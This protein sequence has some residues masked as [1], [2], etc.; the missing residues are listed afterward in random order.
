MLT[1]SHPPD[2]PTRDGQAKLD[3]AGALATARRTIGEVKDK[4]G[5][6]DRER[7]QI[8]E[9]VRVMVVWM[10]VDAMWMGFGLVW[11]GLIYAR[12]SRWEWRALRALGGLTTATITNPRPL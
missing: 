2:T 8:C 11:F 1:S 3:Q 6:G 12:V 10:G 9:D 4:L 7:Y 5:Q